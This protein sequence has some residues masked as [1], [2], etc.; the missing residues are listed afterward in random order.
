MRIS[1]AGRYGKARIVRSSDRMITH[2]ALDSRR[3]VPGSL[4]F[5]LRGKRTDGIDHLKEAERNG[6]VAVLVH[7]EDVPRALNDSSCA[8]LASDDVSLALM[9]LATA[10]RALHPHVRTIG[11]T[12]S[13]GK[14]TTKEAI[15]KIASALGPTTMTSGNLNSEYGLALSIMNLGPETKYGV[16]ELGIDHPGEMERMTRMANP[17]IG[18]LTNIGNAHLES[19]GSREVI[20]RE[21]AKIFH[22]GIEAGFICRTSRYGPLIQTLSPVELIRYSTRDV[23]AIDLGL[24]GWQISYRGVSF[25][26]KAVGKHLLEDVAGAI[27]VGTHLGARPVE[28]AHALEDFEPLVGRSTVQGSRVTIINDTYNASLDSTRSI[29]RYLSRLS[30][31]GRK[32]AVLGPMKEL[33]PE[34]RAAHLEIAKTLVRSTF[35]KHFLYGWEMEEAYQTIKREKGKERVSFTQDFEEL[36]WMVR[37]EVTDGDLVLLKG[38]RVVGMERLIPT[39]EQGVALNG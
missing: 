5:A 39:I 8:V 32:S 3:C 7:T 38:S 2:Y 6:A 35:T 23:S 9:N 30:W 20:A 4:F 11:I 18:V 25:R 31:R 21:K 29:I 1:S 24:D 28:I 34:S 16:F 26:I 17:S 22:P 12:G 10:Y 27:R 36:E 33:G 13:T 14:S 15:G 19:M 37:D